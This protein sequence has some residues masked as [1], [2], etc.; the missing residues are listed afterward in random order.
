MH[1]GGMRIHVAVGS[2]PSH[3]WNERPMDEPSKNVV[4]NTGMLLKGWPLLCAMHAAGSCR[5]GGSAMLV[6]PNGRSQ[7]SSMGI[8]GVKWRCM[9]SGVIAAWLREAGGRG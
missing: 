1:V 5:R 7:F 6:E 8:D 4:P 3:R 9:I 2:R